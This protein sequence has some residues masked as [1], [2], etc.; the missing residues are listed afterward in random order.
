L[1][2]WKRRTVIGFLLAFTAW[3]AVHLALTQVYDLNPWK[4]SGWGMYSAPQLPAHMRVFGLTPDEVGVYEL[5]TAPAEV[6]PA[7]DD[8][9]RHRRA[10]RK[11]IRPDEVADALLDAYSAIDGVRLVVVQPTLNPITGM[12]EENPMSYEYRRATPTMSP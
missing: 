7:L 1:N 12:I 5:G 8:F 2:D 3:P 11:L 9:M 10:L 4:L 6:V